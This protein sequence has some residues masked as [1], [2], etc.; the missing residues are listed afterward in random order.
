MA[1]CADES[2]A[3][4]TLFTIDSA[5]SLDEAERQFDVWKEGYGYSLKV[6]WIDVQDDRGGLTRIWM[7]KGRDGNIIRQSN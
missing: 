7:K 5:L 4:R 3:E 1:V 6:C 2:G